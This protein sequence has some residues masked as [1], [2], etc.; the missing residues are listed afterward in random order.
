MSENTR[1]NLT[2]AV[3]F[4]SGGVM[5]ILILGLASLFYRS[6]TVDLP[7]TDATVVAVRYVSGT[8][9]LVVL[10]GDGKRSIHYY[11]LEDYIPVVG[12]R[13]TVSPGHRI[14]K[15]VLTRRP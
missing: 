6:E 11:R 13:V 7:P 9:V 1:L 14:D 3:A 5:M 10:E 4:L 8:T 12:D 15:V 2:R